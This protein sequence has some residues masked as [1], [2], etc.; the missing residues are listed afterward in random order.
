[1]FKNILLP[2]DLED[3]ALSRQ[4]LDATLDQCRDPD[5]RLYVLTVVPGFGMSI[6][7]QYFPENYE[8]E[9][10]ATAAARLEKFVADNIPSKIKTKVMVANG[11]IY[12]EILKAVKQTGCDLVVMGAHRPGLEEFLLGPNA[13]KV[14]RHA[15]C[16]V[17]VV[18][19]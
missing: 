16:S 9:S 14:V 5:A 15:G 10:I 18:R 7:S 13:A 4:V 11:S 12:E 19:P 2:I 1:M 17:F 3:G 6:V 8:E